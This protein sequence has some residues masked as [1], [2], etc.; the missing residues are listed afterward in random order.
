MIVSLLVEGCDFR[1]KIPETPIS[2]QKSIV[3]HGRRIATHGNS[4]LRDNHRRAKGSDF[5]FVL[6]RFTEKNGGW[7]RSSFRNCSII[8]STPGPRALQSAIWRSVPSCQRASATKCDKD[9]RLGNGPKRTLFLAGGFAVECDPCHG[10]KTRKID[11]LGVLRVV[12]GISR[13]Q[14]GLP[15]LP[16][17]DHIKN[18]LAIRRQFHGPVLGISC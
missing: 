17:L 2:V 3:L 11:P 9:Y 12:L 7:S 10:L 13:D 18:P 4:S 1:L 16:I 6:T 5:T 8:G 14:R 15:V